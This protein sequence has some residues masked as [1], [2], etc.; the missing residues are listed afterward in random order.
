MVVNRNKPF[1]FSRTNAFGAVFILLSFANLFGY[2]DF[3]PDT[4]LDAL[5]E[6]LNGLSI[7][8]L[9]FRTNQP[10]TLR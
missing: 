6:F 10:V 7:I 8:T 3:V 4:N 2:G 5:A 9:R 1:W